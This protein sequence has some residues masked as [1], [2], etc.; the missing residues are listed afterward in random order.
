MYSNYIYVFAR[1]VD[2]VG[3]GTVR[4]LVHLSLVDSADA[5]TNMI[6]K[7]SPFRYLFPYIP[8]GGALSCSYTEWKRGAVRKSLAVTTAVRTR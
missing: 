7:D 6:G 8:N 2:D 4:L 3:C 1:E 5:R